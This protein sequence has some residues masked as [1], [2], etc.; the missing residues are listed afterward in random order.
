MGDL[1][2]QGQS[3]GLGRRLPRSSSSMRRSTVI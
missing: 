2:S 3:L 1:T